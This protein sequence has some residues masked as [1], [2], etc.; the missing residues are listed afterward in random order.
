MNPLI[1]D[2]R[3][4]DHLKGRSKGII[5]RVVTEVSEARGV[6]FREM[7]VG[8]WKRDRVS[9]ARTLAMGICGSMGVPVCHIARAFGRTWATVYSAEM[10]CSRQ[11]RKS[12][13]F[14]K[15]WDRIAGSHDERQSD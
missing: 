3:T 7:F 14:R 15:E 6:D 5:L 10:T 2:H 11:Y 13:E 12:S 1:D 4:C 8:E 9:A